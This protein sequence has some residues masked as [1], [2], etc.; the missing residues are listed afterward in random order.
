MNETIY[1]AIGA[2]YDK[3]RRADEFLTKRF[4]HF[5]SP[6]KNENYLDMGCGTGNYTC[7]LASREYKF[8]GID[9]SELMLENARQRNC[10]VIWKNGDAENLPFE[11]G[12]FRRSS[13]FF[14]NSSLE[15]F[16]ESVLGN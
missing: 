5:L 9:P 11:D 7:A 2:D 15:R 14:N 13:R 10:N 4:Q 6:A 3:T 8:Y 12:F 1:N 16:V